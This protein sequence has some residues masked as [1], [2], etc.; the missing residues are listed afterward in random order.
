MA[1]VLTKCPAGVRRK[2]EALWI[3]GNFR[4]RRE[5]TR[6]CGI[7]SVDSPCWYLDAAIGAEETL[8]DPSPS[9]VD[10]TRE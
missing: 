1:S 3:V 9:G 10:G 2:W 6:C 5:A 7:G 8:R 4:V